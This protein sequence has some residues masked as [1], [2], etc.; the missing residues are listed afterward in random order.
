MTATSQNGWPALA[1]DSHLL[2][3]WSIPGASGTTRLRLRNGSAGFLLCHLA[4]WF[5][6]KV[7]GLVEPLLDDWG[8]AYRPVRGYETTLSNHSSGTAM[9][10]NATDHPL[11]VEDT[12][13]LTEQR[14]IGKRLRLYDGAIR[15]G[16]DYRGRKDEMHFE[17]NAPL[18][19]CEKVARKLM[20][21]PRGRL[22][23]EANP[24]QRKVI[25]S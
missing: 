6:S 17:I 9:D 15:W 16:G 5:D 4:T 19:D 12:F 13:S 8:Y 10:L 7:E 25:L 1:A 11:G 21:T 20:E 18:S 14:H 23:L 24:G 3:T 22:V 2:Y